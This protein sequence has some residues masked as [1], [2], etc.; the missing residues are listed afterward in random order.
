M[1]FAQDAGVNHYTIRSYDAGEVCV[2]RTP[3]TGLSP[4]PETLH[5]SLVL[6]P[7]QLVRDWP[8]Q[9]F[10]ALL[11]AHFDIF[12]ELRPEV[13]LLGCGARQRFLPPPLLAHLSQCGIPVE[14]MNTGAACRTYNILAGDGR[15]IAAALLLI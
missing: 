8:P 3:D 2:L 11:P 15:N 1:Q 14:L 9:Q 12:D 4:A 7:R 6:T 13:I 10:D 5:Q